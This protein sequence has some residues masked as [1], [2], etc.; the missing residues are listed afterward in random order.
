MPVVKTEVKK[1]K[2]KKQ[3][4]KAHP[5]YN[6][7]TDTQI[8]NGSISDEFAKRVLKG[9]KLKKRVS[10]KTKVKPPKRKI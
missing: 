1:K 8:R 10:E 9:D 4:P 6:F 5:S 2:P 7:T 3:G